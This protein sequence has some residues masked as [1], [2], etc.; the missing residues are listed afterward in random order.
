[1]RAQQI[2][3]IATTWVSIC[4][5]WFR[6]TCRSKVTNSL[7]SQRYFSKLW[8]RLVIGYITAPN[9]QGYQTLQNYPHVSSLIFGSG[10][11]ESLTVNP[12]KGL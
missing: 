12:P 3:Q 5:K 4:A 10:F 11:M 1:M 7:Y 9:A 6:R 2:S 8:G